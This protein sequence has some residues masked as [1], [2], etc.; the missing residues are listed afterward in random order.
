MLTRLGTLVHILVALLVPIWWATLTAGSLSP[1]LLVLCGLLGLLP[2]IDTA[3]SHIGRLAPELSVVIERRWGHRTITHSLWAV[4]LV[5]LLTVP[6]TNRF[7]VLH[8]RPL[9]ERLAAAAH[10]FGKR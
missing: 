5:G 7:R 4:L 6:L 3:T 10:S 1:G 9:R 8:T 2:D